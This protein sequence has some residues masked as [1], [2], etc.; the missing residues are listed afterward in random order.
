MLCTRCHDRVD[1]PPGPTAGVAPLR[2]AWCTARMS[3]AA[4]ALAC[5]IALLV[6]AHLAAEARGLP[7]ARAATKVGASLAFV[8]LALLPGPRGP[9]AGGLLAGLALSVVGDAALLSARRAAFLGGLAAFLLAHL[10]YAAAFASAGHPDPWVALPVA[11]FL[12]GTLR[13]LW[14]RLGPMRLPVVAYCLAIGAMLWLAQG[15]ARP[16]VRLGAVLFAASDLFVARNRFVRPGLA[17]RAIG[18][19]LYYAAQVLLALAVR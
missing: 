13:W 12:A 6:A 15:V 11:A 1:G 8:A 4:W 3:P 7:L 2:P 5:T 18:L 9:L 14:P 17:N 10:A 16:E 19:P